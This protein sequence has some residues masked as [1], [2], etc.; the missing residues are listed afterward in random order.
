MYK[1]NNN[2]TTN[3]YFFP[4]EAQRRTPFNKRKQEELKQKNKLQPNSWAAP[5]SSFKGTY[6]YYKQPQV[7]DP[8]SP[9]N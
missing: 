8:N 2:L 9:R 4:Y 6:P 5:P 7:T 1:K 3:S